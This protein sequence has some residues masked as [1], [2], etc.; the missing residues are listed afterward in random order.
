MVVSD[1]CFGGCFG[2]VPPSREGR[3]A[4]DLLSTSVAPTEAFTTVCKQNSWSVVCYKGV[5][6]GCPVCIS[7]VYLLDIQIRYIHTPLYYHTL[8]HYTV[9]VSL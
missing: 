1:F 2:L 8:L 4:H 7:T 6:G 3:A 5:A 9:K